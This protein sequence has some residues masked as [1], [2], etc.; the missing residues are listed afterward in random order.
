[1]TDTR[2]VATN[3]YDGKALIPRVTGNVGVGKSIYSGHIS[4]RMSR[5]QKLGG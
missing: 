5:S 1:M 2:V 4:C 3:S